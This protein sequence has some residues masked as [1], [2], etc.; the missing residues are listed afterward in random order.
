[1]RKLFVLVLVALVI[2]MFTPQAIRI[3]QQFISSHEKSSWAVFA[4]YQLG[5][6]CFWTLSYSRA[7]ECYRILLS[8]YGGEPTRRGASEYPVADPGKLATAMFRIA[9]S[10]ERL[11]NYDAAIEVY[12]RFVQTYPKHTEAD[13]ARSQLEKLR[14]VH[15]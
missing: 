1:M 11:K 14:T 12:D 6:L 2:F 13:H 4:Q 8:K 3:F 7:V 15:Q 5:N 10:Y 9:V